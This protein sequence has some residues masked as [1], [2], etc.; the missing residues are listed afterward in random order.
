M[1]PKRSYTWNQK[2]FFYGDSRR[3]PQL[4]FSGRTGF[5]KTFIF[6]PPLFPSLATLAPW[7][8]NSVQLFASALPLMLMWGEG[9]L[10]TPHRSLVSRLSYGLLRCYWYHRPSDSADVI[11]HASVRDDR[12]NYSL[13]LQ[14]SETKCQEHVT[15]HPHGCTISEIKPCP[16]IFELVLVLSS[17]SCFSSKILVREVESWVSLS[18][19][20]FYKSYC[21]HIGC[22]LHFSL[23]YLLCDASILQFYCK[24]FSTVVE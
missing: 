6:A 2:G 19:I 3:I 21:C 14:P 17:L 1:G 18:H 22:L 7:C 5:F 24:A 11:M 4:M 13:R 9:V 8:L 23:K 10:A 20:I 12:Y 16:V 15:L